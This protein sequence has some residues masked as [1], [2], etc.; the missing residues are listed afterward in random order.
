METAPFNLPTFD[1]EAE[2]IVA[3]WPR[4]YSCAGVQLRPGDPV[5][6]T[7]FNGRLLRSLYES[8]WIKMAA[9][10][11]EATSQTAKTSSQSGDSTSDN[12]LEVR[13]FGQGRWAVMRGDERLSDYKPR[14]K[15]FRDMERMVADEKDAAK[16]AANAR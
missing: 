14:L 5:D 15:A 4:G 2:F 11:L 1:R 10:P 3:A 7:K 12:A 13:H 16:A 9:K 8:R 6:K